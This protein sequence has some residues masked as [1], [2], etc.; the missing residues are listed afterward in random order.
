M[1]MYL[2]LTSKYRDASLFFGLLNLTL[3][4]R[5]EINC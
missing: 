1:F 4:G 5:Y 2:L 3:L